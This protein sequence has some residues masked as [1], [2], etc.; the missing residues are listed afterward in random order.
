MQTWERIQRQQRLEARKQR[1]DEEKED[2]HRIFLLGKLVVETIPSLKGI[3][4]FKGKGATA[5][6]K[7]SVA[8]FGKFLSQ[9]AENEELMAQ[10]A[11]EIRRGLPSEE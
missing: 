7:A 4:V 11:E 9:L 2:N 8:P 10:L 1:E 5:R 6:N 3:Q